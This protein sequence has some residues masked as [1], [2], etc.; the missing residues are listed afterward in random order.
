MEG[1]EHLRVLREKVLSDCRPDAAFWTCHGRVVR[2][3]YELTDA[4][5]TMSESSFSYHVN[6]DHQKND[7]AKWIAEVLEDE[8]LA[9]K[10]VHIT[11][12][13]LY[14]K[15]IRNRIRELESPQ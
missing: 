14:L 6:S 8:E 3:I 10:L 2:N 1:L 13:Q 9:L 4:I 5:Q 12:K 15:I 11:D 7:F